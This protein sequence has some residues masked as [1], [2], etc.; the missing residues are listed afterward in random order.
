MA[1]LIQ[2]IKYSRCVE[3]CEL[4]WKVIREK[5]EN[6]INK[7]HRLTGRSRQSVE[8]KNYYFLE[9]C[10]GE[11]IYISKQTAE[12]LCFLH[13]IRLSKVPVIENCGSISNGQ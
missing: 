12:S 13:G 7:V 3:L 10:A 8:I 9:S 2:Q 1:S 11:K 5:H 6:N 4:G